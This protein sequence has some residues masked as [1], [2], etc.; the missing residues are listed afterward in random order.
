MSVIYKIKPATSNLVI[1][2]WENIIQNLA[3]GLTHTLPIVSYDVTDLFP[4]WF[5]V[6]ADPVTIIT[7]DGTLF[8]IN[9]LASYTIST[10]GL[11]KFEYV[12]TRWYMT[13]TDMVPTSNDLKLE[14]TIHVAKNG[15]DTLAL[16]SVFQPFSIK[17]PF[18]T[19]EA[20]HAASNPNHTIMVW[21]G[22]YTMTA[23]LDFDGT[24]AR[25]IYHQPGVTITSYP[26]DYQYKITP[27]EN[28]Q[29]LGYPDYN[30]KFPLWANTAPNTDICFFEWEFGNIVND[31]LGAVFQAATF[32]SMKGSMRGRKM[33]DCYFS[34]NAWNQI[35]FKIDE[36]VGA[37]S[38]FLQFD[39]PNGFNGT[40]WISQYGNATFNLSGLSK[41]F[42]KIDKSQ[43]TNSAQSL[44]NVQQ[45]GY[46]TD[47]VIEIDANFITMD[48][49]G[50][51]HD[52]SIIRWRGNAY[53]SKSNLVGNEMPFYYATSPV[54]GGDKN[55]PVMEHWGTIVT[56]E[57][58]T[59]PFRNCTLIQIR[60]AGTFIWHGN[61]KEAG[62]DDT[63]I[64][65]PFP[66]IDVSNG[67]VDGT[68]RVIFDGVFMTGQSATVG[69]IRLNET[70]NETNDLQ[71]IF[72]NNL[73]ICEG[74][75]KN[76]AP[77]YSTT[78]RP[79]RLF[80]LHSLGITG[81]LDPAVFGNYMSNNRMY[82]DTDVKYKISE[83]ID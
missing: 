55:K 43:F 81:E 59:Y 32:A 15:D 54:S 53:H 4:V 80:V 28:A 82:Y 7:V 20:A 18:L 10:P 70:G 49:P 64:G 23:P 63:G 58:E 83:Y 45:G 79:T 19:I 46:A 27:Q 74:I 77:I 39:D 26:S 16:A 30:M 44:I 41:R 72:M 60:C 21:P 5:L 3:P 75:E 36:W 17:F 8:N 56:R 47:R 65:T 13:T 29:I 61:Y 9:S 69:P 40:V 67:D 35:D 50:F 1:N 24:K 71:A 11:Y 66:V 78:G 57:S 62:F 37:T 2:E 73:A 22:K 14:N 34:A 6:G 76:I 42:T 68:T 12:Q 52:A 48:S 31:S 33:S 51:N 25:K 38:S